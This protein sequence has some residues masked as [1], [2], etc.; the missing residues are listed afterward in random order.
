MPNQNY[1]TFE[2]QHKKAKDAAVS[3]IKEC[4]GIEKIC[5]YYKKA[6]GTIWRM[7]YNL[8]SMMTEELDQQYERYKG[9]YESYMKLHGHCLVLS[10]N[11]D[12]DKRDKY[13]T[14]LRVASGSGNSITRFE[15]EGYDYLKEIVIEDNCFTGVAYFKLEGLRCLEKVIVGK[16]SFTNGEYVNKYYNTNRSFVIANC[17]ELTL[18]DIGDCSFAEYGG[19]WKLSG[20]DKLERLRIVSEEETS[21]NFNASPFVLESK[22]S[23]RWQMVGLNHLEAVELG[24]HAFVWTSKIHLEGRFDNCIVR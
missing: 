11:E 12:L 1:A 18:I 19:E 24:Y 14:S 20:L 10:G 21:Y 17:P 4:S 2:Y 9:L 16:K 7:N 13:L 23:E 8:T 15:L 3:A 5:I 6:D 22:Y